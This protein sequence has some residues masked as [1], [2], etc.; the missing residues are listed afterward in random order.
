M[1]AV[2]KANYD[3]LYWYKHCLRM[4]IRVL[5]VIHCEYQVIC[6]ALER[7]ELLTFDGFVI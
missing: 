4:V 6:A 1:Y 3:G 2:F 5:W 7:A